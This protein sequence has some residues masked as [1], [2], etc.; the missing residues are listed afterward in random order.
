M[1]SIIYKHINKYQKNADGKNEIN[2]S[3]ENW[4]SVELNFK[5]LEALIQEL[6]DKLSDTDNSF[7]LLMEE[8]RKAKG[9]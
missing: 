7:D 3:R 9:L 1:K 4:E 5:E 8:I 2:L 6:Q